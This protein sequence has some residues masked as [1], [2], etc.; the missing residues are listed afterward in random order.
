MR[1]NI[2]FLI[3]YL[4]NISFFTI[5]HDID[6]RTTYSLLKY[7]SSDILQFFSPAIITISKFNSLIYLIIFS[8]SLNT[9]IYLIPFL[10][11]SLLVHSWTVLIH[12]SVSNI[13]SIK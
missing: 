8:T 6:Y 12:L 2:I 3:F 10:A 11:F 5:G 1:A 9:N 13:L 4:N 7:I